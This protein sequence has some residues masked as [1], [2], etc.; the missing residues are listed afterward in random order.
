MLPGSSNKT[1]LNQVCSLILSKEDAEKVQLG[2]S[3]EVAFKPVFERLGNQVGILLEVGVYKVLY[4][5]SSWGGVNQVCWGRISSLE[6]GQ[7]ISCCGEEYTVQKRER[8]SNIIFPIILRL[9][10]RISSVEE[11]KGTEIFWGKNQN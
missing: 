1:K 2:R 4:P 11:R 8:G 9:L 5:L 7:V 6:E 10:G 3:Y